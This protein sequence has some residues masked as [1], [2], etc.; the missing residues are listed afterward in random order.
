MSLCDY[1]HKSLPHGNMIWR[2]CRI[3]RRIQSF[4]AAVAKT[5]MIPPWRRY[6]D[7]Y[8]FAIFGVDIGAPVSR[9]LGVFEAIAV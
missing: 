2:D 5:E 3:W 7:D 1:L 6:R 4:L 9:V 8:T